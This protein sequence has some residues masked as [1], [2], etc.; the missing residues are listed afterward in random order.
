[1]A[2][3]NGVPRRAGPRWLVLTGL[4]LVLAAVAAGCG[5]DDE[6]SAAD[7]AGDVCS[8]FSD[9]TNSLE[10]AA[11]P[12]RSGDISEDSIDDAV[13]DLA[14]ATEQFVDD[15]RGLGPPD[16]DAGEEAQEE[17]DGLADDLSEGVDD[18]RETVDNASASG[19]AAALAEIGNTLTRMASEAQSAF[20]RIEGLEAADELESAF[21]D[22]PECE[23][24]SGSSS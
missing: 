20:S 5:G 19:A 13:S 8:A 15:I 9:W 18:I 16:T 24:L 2:P 3:M 1:M 17:L 23:E 4:A 22:A 11:E 6:A 12:L 10:S 21:R 7:W 14:D